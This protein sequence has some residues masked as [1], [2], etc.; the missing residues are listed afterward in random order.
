[1][2]LDSR[3]AV[4]WIIDNFEG[5]FVDHAD[6]RG[7]PTKYGVTQETLSDYR[8]QSVSKEDVQTLTHIEASDLLTTLYV[9]RPGYTRIHDPR[10][11]T[12]VVDFAI[13][14]GPHTATKTLQRIVKTTPDGLFG[15]ITEKAVNEYPPRSL[16]TQL[17]AHRL[18]HW[19]KIFQRDERQRV[20]AAG[21]LNRLST[22]LEYL[23]REA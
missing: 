12:A 1:M 23:E 8:G 14:S 13:H 18:S 2:H 9:T 10:L 11:R 15:P 22:L 21:W 20:F 5:G 17:V 7:G 6:D 4:Q 3:E 16:E 19:A